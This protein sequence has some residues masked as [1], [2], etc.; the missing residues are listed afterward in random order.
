[1]LHELGEGGGRV[2]FRP[3]RRLEREGERHVVMATTTISLVLHVATPL[4]CTN[5]PAALRASI[6]VL[7]EP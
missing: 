4:R 3:H 6:R 2:L 5:S 1:M 7:L